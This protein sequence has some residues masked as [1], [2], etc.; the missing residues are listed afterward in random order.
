M[1]LWFGFFR[2]ELWKSFDEA[3]STELRPECEWRLDPPPTLPLLEGSEL[4]FSLS[5][6]YLV[7]LTPRWMGLAIGSACEGSDRVVAQYDGAG[8]RLHWWARPVYLATLHEAK[9]HTP[10]SH[11]EPSNTLSD[12]RSSQGDKHASRP[13]ETSHRGSHR[14]PRTLSTLTKQKRAVIKIPH[15]LLETSTDKARGESF[16]GGD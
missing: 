2:M 11:Q 7:T 8:L 10:G 13:V 1:G 15:P 14:A 3:C 5:L 4:H 6:A 16:V 12:P 9:Q